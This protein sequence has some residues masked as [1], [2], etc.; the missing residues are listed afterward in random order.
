[1]KN[2]HQ[3]SRRAII[4]SSVFGFLTVSIPSIAYARHIKKTA[5]DRENP[6]ELFHRYPSIDD[7][8]VQQVVGASHFNFDKVKELVNQRPEL[9]RATWDWSFGDWE[10]ALG[11]ASH[12][13]R[14]D[15]ATY[16]IDKGARPDIF[17]LAMLGHY[18]AVKTMIESVDDIQTISGPHGIS[19]L[20]HAKAGL[21]MKDK[22]TTTQIKS[23]EKLISYLEKLGNAGNNE[24]NIEMSEEEK[25]KYIGDYRYGE[26]AN[27]G[28]TVKLNMRNLLSLG[29]LGKG[30]GSLY[31]TGA[32]EFIYNGITSVK[33]TFKEKEGKIVSLTVHEPDLVLTA[34]KIS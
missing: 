6:E 8:I 34:K 16:L 1:M 29:K 15:I 23:C 4:K 24:P 10:T 12:V 21:R 5:G 17:A 9:S 19:L 27:Q 11:A 14:R 30:G 20:Q 26:K 18:K 2:M 32:H 31:K 25:A 22:M 3:P 7:A 33:I 28:F 13:G